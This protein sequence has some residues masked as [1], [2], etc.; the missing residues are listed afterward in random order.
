MKR[1]STPLLFA[2]LIAA[3]C[4][5][6]LAGTVSVTTHTHSTEGLQGVTANTASNAIIYQLGAA[7]RQ[8]D[9][10]TYTFPN[11]ALVNNSFATVFNMLPINSPNENQ[12]IAGLTFGLLNSDANSV[13]Y[14]ITS[15]ALPNNGAT[16]PVEWQNGSSI[17]GIMTLGRINYIT[18]S[19]LNQNITVTV[20]SQ[21]S[22]GDILDS[23]GT[24]TAT[25][26]ETRSQFGTAAVT[27]QLN[28]IIDVSRSL[29]LFTPN[30]A[31]TFTWSITNPDT[32]G[33]INLAVINTTVQDLY[34]TAGKFTGLTDANFTSGGTL[35]V[36]TNTAK[37]RV[38]YAGQPST[39]T[40]TFTAPGGV[41]LQTQNFT[42]DFIYNYTSAGAV[43]GAA[44]IGVNVASGNWSAIGHSLVTLSANTA[45][46]AEAS[47]TSTITATMSNVSFEDVTVGLSYSGTATS[48]ADYITPAA[49]I[50]ITAGQTQGS[51]TLIAIDDTTLEAEETI[52]VDVT[53]VTGGVVTENGNQQQT[54]RIADN[55]TTAVSLSVNNTNIAETGG[56]STITA[57]LTKA[58]YENMT[59]HLSFTGS[60]INTDFTAQPE[61][62]TLV[63]GQTA[64]SLTLS[65]NH[66]TLVEGDE[67][68]IVDISAVA[69]GNAFESGTQ[70]QTINIIDDDYSP[71]SVS[72]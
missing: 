28:G 52:V 65:A 9:K 20:S 47:G 50:V 11:G 19:L 70:Q 6:A 12:A 42:S 63:A 23:A 38:S 3:N 37:V 64:G 8:G 39:D 59:V 44:V 5:T 17:G 54:T 32:T 61:H 7:Y 10:I 45:V 72:L 15:L 14:R 35:T 67:S 21:T 68:L 69:G 43:A 58:T 51:T 29:N 36:D 56:S 4:F 48:G 55:D 33:W 26:A 13:T 57:T 40:I 18:S 41:A 46:I 22:A 16:P 2:L 31:D 53:S 49:T 1:Y 30:A 60:A 25:V 24:R 66:D 27:Q 71:V 34:G 62:I